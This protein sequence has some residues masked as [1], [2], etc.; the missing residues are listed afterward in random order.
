[1]CGVWCLVQSEFIKYLHMV[2]DLMQSS[3]G[4]SGAIY[5]EVTDVEDE[6]NGLYT[7]DRQ[8]QHC[9]NLNLYLSPFISSPAGSKGPAFIG[10]TG[11]SPR[12]RYKYLFRK[13]LGFFY[14]HCFTMR[15]FEIEKFKAMA[16]AADCT[17]C[18]VMNG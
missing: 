4:L 11:H 5:T 18:L 12:P 2:K 1:M 6:V 3:S 8:V 16:T 14:S 15:F 17:W 13:L 7:Y 10:C 9:L